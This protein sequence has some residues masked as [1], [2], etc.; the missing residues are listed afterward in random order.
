LTSRRPAGDHPHHKL[1]N[2]SGLPDGFS[3]GGFELTVFI[4]VVITLGVGVLFYV[5]GAPTRAEHV[6]LPLGAE[7]A[8]P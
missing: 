1:L 4:P 6:D 3:R 5:L 8:S 7:P 2:N